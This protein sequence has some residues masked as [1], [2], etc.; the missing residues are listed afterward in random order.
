M[1]ISAIS[2]LDP[3]GVDLEPF[4]DILKIANEPDLFLLAGDIYEYRNPEI[5]GLIIDFFKVKKWSCPIIAVFGNREFDEDID[6]I[7]RICKNRIKFLDDESIELKIKN[8][9]IGVVGTRGSLDVPTWWQSKH[10]PDIRKAYLERIKKCEELLN[11]LNVDIKIL[12]SHYSP[13]Y[14]TLKGEDPRIYSGLGSKKF[15]NVLIKTKTSFAIHGHAHYGIPLAFVDSI[16]V[17]NVAFEVNNKIVEIDPD[18]LPKPGLSKF[19]K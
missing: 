4:W 14:K 2:D 7:K 8:K 18:N 3:L 11:N 15:E 19:V 13:T 16:P 5:Y 10:V 1:L 12:L 17:F 6:E 9:K